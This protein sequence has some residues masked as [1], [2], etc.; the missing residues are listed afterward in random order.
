MSDD[1]IRG[2]LKSAGLGDGDPRAVNLSADVHAILNAM[3][4][5]MRERILSIAAGELFTQPE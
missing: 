5:E 2:M 4:S 1:V 3:R